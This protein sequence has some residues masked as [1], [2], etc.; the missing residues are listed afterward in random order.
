MLVVTANAGGRPNTWDD[1]DYKGFRPGTL[2]L[3]TQGEHPGTAMFT[4]SERGAVRGAAYEA[5][6]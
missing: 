5:A 3:F 6:Q 4:D 1:P 2:P